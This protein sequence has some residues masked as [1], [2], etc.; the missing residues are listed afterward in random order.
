MWVVDTTGRMTKGVRPGEDRVEAAGPDAVFAAVRARIAARLDAGD[1][2][3]ARVAC[4]G[5]SS[6][7]AAALSAYWAAGADPTASEWVH[8]GPDGADPLSAALGL[9]GDPR[10]RLAADGSREVRTIRIEHPRLGAARLGFVVGAGAGMAA[11]DALDGG[12]GTGARALVGAARLLAGLVG[13]L[14]GG[15]S[16]LAGTVR[17]LGYG[18]P[19][20]PDSGGPE[21]GVVRGTRR[22]LVRE[23]EVA[24]SW[25]VDGW[26]FDDEAGIARVRVGPTVR[27]AA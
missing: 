4:V 13:E 20:L 8:G 17:E 9:G 22:G 12:L 27:F 21:I 16:L 2:E 11:L 1:E 25:C 6:T 26:R 5:R 19:V 23:V 18:P 7:T 15:Q 14:T 3:P 10:R 24:G